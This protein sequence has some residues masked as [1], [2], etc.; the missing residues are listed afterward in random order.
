MEIYCLF[1]IAN[2]YG[3]PQN[4]LVA[5]WT[6]KPLLSQLREIFGQDQD[7]DPLMDIQ[8]GADV[9]INDTD[10]RLE[11]VKEGATLSRIK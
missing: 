4:N 5:W 3:Q 11:R 8:G 1:S 9:R 7:I 10:Y 6:E 2:D